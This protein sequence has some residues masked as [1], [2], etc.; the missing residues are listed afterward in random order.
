MGGP[1]ERDVVVVGS[2]PN[3]LAAA[4]TLASAGLDV[5]LVEGA[6]TLGG[7]TRSAELTLPGVLHDVCSAAHPLAAAAPF[8]APGGGPDGT[9]FDLAAHGVRLLQP[10]VPLA[11]AMD[12][13]R[14]AVLHRRLEDTVDDLDDLAPGDGRSW[15]RVVGPLVADADTLVRALTSDLRRVPIEPRRLATLARFG[16]TIAG[17][18]PG[19]ARRFRGPAPGA[20][21]AGSA[22]HTALRLD[23]PVPSPA[24]AA[25]GMLLNVLGH[26][27]GWP[28][29]EGGSQRIA[30]AVVA[31][32]RRLGATVRT[33]EWVHDLRQLPRARATLL[34]LSPA[35]L[36][37]L[38]GDALPPSY[39]RALRRYRYGAG[40]STVHLV[41]SEPLP[42][43]DPRAREAG[44]VHLGGP[45]AE[46]AAAEAA[47]ADGRH[48]AH[49]FVLLVQP[50]VVDP[51]R[52]PEGLHPV[53]AYCHVPAGSD[54]DVTDVLL[55]RIERYAP[56]ARDTVVATAVR[57]AARLALDNPVHVG[58][59]VA[60]GETTLRQVLARPVPRWDPYRTPLDGVW[61]CS[62][63][64]PPGPGVHGMCGVHAA[65]SVLR[66]LAGS[67]RV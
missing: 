67:R 15:R 58:G 5:E 61:L 62:S 22:A 65:R 33:G 37:A 52:A 29:V 23:G 46:V 8:L 43:A 36:D 64:T 2:G 40:A 13:G 44:T 16:L 27:A 66:H 25:A 32:L 3:G 21:L 18:V 60:V 31:D 30:D 9:G 39:R 38:G 47:V 49:P 7:G 17:G 28:V 63:A 12:G 41:T 1:F 6:D 20:L 26:A 56:G 19:F 54:V 51:T 24:P 42:W 35:Q 50:S 53:W 34:D 55:R 10:R 14:F 48:A 11:H 45:G 59:D 4:W 57:P